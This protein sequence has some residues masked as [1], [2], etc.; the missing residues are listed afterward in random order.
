V[1]DG[2]FEDVILVCRTER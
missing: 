2:Y 1:V